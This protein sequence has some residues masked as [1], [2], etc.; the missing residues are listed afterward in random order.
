MIKKKLIKCA[1]SE[2]NLSE[3]REGFLAEKIGVILWI[4]LTK[5]LT[6]KGSTFKKL[7]L[8]GLSKTTGVYG[9]SLAPRRVHLRGEVKHFLN[10]KKLFCSSYK[11]TEALSLK[12]FWTFCFLI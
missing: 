9:H 5:L 11:R 2:I 8:G 4:N 7:N 6:R 3:F 10:K 12:K 1:A